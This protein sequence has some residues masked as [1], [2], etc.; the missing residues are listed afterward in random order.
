MTA[1]LE[2]SPVAAVWETWLRSIR[3]FPFISPPLRLALKGVQKIRTSMN[4]EKKSDYIYHHKL[5]HGGCRMHATSLTKVYHV[6]A[7]PQH[8]AAT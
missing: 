4:R 6:G 2:L 3:R 5:F 7:C 1:L 8:S